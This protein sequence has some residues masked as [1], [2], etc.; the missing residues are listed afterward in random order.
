MT[1]ARALALTM[2][3]FAAAAAAGCCRKSPP[4]PPEETPVA[5]APK[6]KSGC[7]SNAECKAGMKCQAGA[8]VIGDCSQNPSVCPAGTYC[9]QGTCNPIPKK[10]TP[11]KQCSCAHGKK[12][13]G[14][15]GRT[16]CETWYTCDADGGYCVCNC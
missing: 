7:S 3:L 5:E 10:T 4:P 2:T 12:Y 14:P 11:T 16:G 15:C 6:P 8:C 13:W 1:L 9:I